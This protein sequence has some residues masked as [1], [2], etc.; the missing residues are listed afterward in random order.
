MANIALDA[1]KVVLKNGK[2][3]CTCCGGIVC[4]CDDS[5]CG[6][7]ISE[8]LYNNF[9][10]GGNFTMTAILSESSPE[11]SCSSNINNE[12]VFS[13]ELC[14]FNFSVSEQ[15]CSGSVFFD[16]AYLNLIISVCKENTSGLYKLHYNGGGR[17]PYITGSGFFYCYSVGYSIYDFGCEPVG[18]IFEV[19][20]NIQ[21]NAYG[22]NFTVPIWS[23]PPTTGFI[24]SA[25]GTITI[26]SF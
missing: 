12:D 22:F 6:I 20:G 8:S 9:I 24:A 7:V 19:I 21:V 25:N 18:S 15:K 13:G 23:F 3:S 4:P 14:N 16:Y 5:E 26:T 1:G 17:C 2:A 11:G 10:S